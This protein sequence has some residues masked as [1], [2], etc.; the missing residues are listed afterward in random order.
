MENLVSG[1]KIKVARLALSQAITGTLRLPRVSN[2]RGTVGYRVS[3]SRK[4][5]GARPTLGGR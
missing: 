2:Y 3:T 4:Q 1:F 5:G